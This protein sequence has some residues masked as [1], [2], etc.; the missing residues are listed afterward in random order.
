MTK[1]Y[2]L[3]FEIKYNY[4]DKVKLLLVLKNIFIYIY[5]YSTDSVNCLNVMRYCELF[6]LTKFEDFSSTYIY[7]FTLWMQIQVPISVDGYIINRM[8]KLLYHYIFKFNI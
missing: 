2:A 5:Y 7:F 1:F 6:W 8:T 4:F 3:F